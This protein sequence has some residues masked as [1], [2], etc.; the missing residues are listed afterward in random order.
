MPTELP[1]DYDAFKAEVVSDQGDDN[2]GVY[3]G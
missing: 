1:P 2:Q 3:E